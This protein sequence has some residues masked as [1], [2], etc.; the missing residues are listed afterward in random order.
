METLL[1]VLEVLVDSGPD[2]NFEVEYSVSFNVMEYA[3]A[4]IGLAMIEW[5]P[6]AEP[7][8]AWYLRDQ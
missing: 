4:L 1:G 7:R 5:G 8:R 6:N 3:L 2:P